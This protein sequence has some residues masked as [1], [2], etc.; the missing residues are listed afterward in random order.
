MANLFA[1]LGFNYTD[2]NSDI[3]PL[4]KDVVRTLD[5]MPKMLQDWQANDIAANT[6]GGYFTNPCAN[7]TFD[8]WNLSNTLVT[9]TESLQG[10][11]NLTGLWAQI[12]LT[13]ADIS[14]NATSN[15]QAGDFL[16]HT[17]RISGVTSIYSELDDKTVQLPFYDT[18]LQNGKALV[19]I[20]YQTDGIQNNAPIMGHFTSILVANTLSGLYNTINSFVTTVNNSISIS[21]GPPPTP[22]ISTSNLTF[23]TVNAIATAANSINSTFYIRRTHDEDFFKNSTQL[24]LDYNKVNGIG[25]GSSEQYLIKNYI[26]TNKL[27]SRLG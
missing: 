21:G 11:G 16:E 9:V 1:R 27:K 12:N 6:A 22:F 7:V 8:I 14:N 25:T 20:L 13:L 17:N 24:L 3:T 23:N 4:S 19:S 5:S 26:G 10:S 18:A 2:T 15:T